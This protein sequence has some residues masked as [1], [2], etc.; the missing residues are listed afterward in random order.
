MKDVFYH[1]PHE[2]IGIH[3]PSV[4]GQSKMLLMNKCNDPTFMTLKDSSFLDIMQYLPGNAH[5]ILNDSKVVNARL[6]VLDSVGETEKRFEV[7]LLNPEAPTVDP[8]EA[9][10]SP[11]VKQV[12]SCMIRKTCA[13]GE[14]LQVVSIN[15]QD[16]AYSLKVRVVSIEEVWE[17]EDFGTGTG[18]KVEILVSDVASSISMGE[19]LSHYGDVPIPPYLYRDTTPSDQGEG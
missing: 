5:L 17:E 8:R 18:C 13:I 7:M 19:A 12:W 3:A 4:R 11:A 10:A 16:Q 9:L 2:K 1:L 14:E 6:W 15:G